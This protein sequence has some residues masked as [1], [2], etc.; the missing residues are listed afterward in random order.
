VRP[1]CIAP[2]TQ[3]AVNNIKPSGVAMET[4]Q[5]DISSLLLSHRKFRTA[6]NNIKPSG[7]AMKTQQW[8]RFSLLLSHKKFRTAVNNINTL[9]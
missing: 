2:N 7:V 3:V 5:W 8:D 4:Q 6:V 1:R 9:R